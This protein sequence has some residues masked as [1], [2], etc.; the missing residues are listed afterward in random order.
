MKPDAEIAAQLGLPSGTGARL[1]E[2]VH[3]F[4]GGSPLRRAPPM[5]PLMPCLA[6]KSS[7]RGLALTTGCQHSTGS[8]FGRGTSVISWSS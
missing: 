1:A 5:M 4:L 3:D 2:R 6:M 8:V 7:A